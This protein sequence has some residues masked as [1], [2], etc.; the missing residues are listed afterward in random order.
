MLQNDAIKSCI[1]A[2][3]HCCVVL[4]PA[5]CEDLDL[6]VAIFLHICEHNEG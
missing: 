4:E 3:Q 6:H 1:V 2:Q 5:F